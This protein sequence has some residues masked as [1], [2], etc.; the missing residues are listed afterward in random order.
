MY[1]GQTPVLE[2]DIFET[3]FGW[4]GVVASPNGIRRLT[5]PERSRADAEAELGGSIQGAVQDSSRFCELRARLDRY[6][7]GEPEDLTR[8]EIDLGDPEFFTRVRAACRTIPAGET[9]TYSWLARVAG[10]PNASRAAGQAMARNPVPLLVPCHRVV[11]S[12]GRLHG[13]GGGIGLP[14][15]AR[16]LQLEGFPGIPER[17]WEGEQLSLSDWAN[18]RVS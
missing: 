11:G 14:L 7:S 15:K 18:Q 5:L 16:L 8:E 3:A 1:R 9:R 6:F 2:Y 13:F 10:R 4:I 12:D 17:T